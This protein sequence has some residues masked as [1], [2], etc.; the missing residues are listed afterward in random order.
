MK[1]R[2]VMGVV[3]LSLLPLN[4]NANNTLPWQPMI[5]QEKLELSEA[6]RLN[7]IKFNRLILLL[8]FYLYLDFNF[9]S[10][11]RS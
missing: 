8:N 11:V 2:V 6:F 10:S 1:V 3:G 4:Y 7:D 5:L 9:E